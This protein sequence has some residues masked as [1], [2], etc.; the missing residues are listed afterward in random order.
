MRLLDVTRIVTVPLG[1]KTIEEL[2]PVIARML[3]E[4]Q[5][6]RQKTEQQETTINELKRKL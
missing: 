5:Y 6:L 3:E 4:L 2:L 1:A